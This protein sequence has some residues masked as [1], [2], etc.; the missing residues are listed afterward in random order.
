VGEPTIVTYKILVDGP[1]SS[2]KTSFIRAIS[3]IDV[4][5]TQKP[6]SKTSKDAKGKG[7]ISVA[8]DFG[9]ITSAD[10]TVTLY[11]FGTPGAWRFD[12]DFM[13]ETLGEGILG[14]VF[15]VDSRKPETFREAVYRLRNFRAHSSLPIVI[16]A[17][18]QDSPDAW[19][20]DTLRIAL[21]IPNDIPIIPC[22]A[23]DRE[24]V[25][26]VVIALLNEVLKD[27]ETDVD[28]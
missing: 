21:R 25:K 16:A 23:T 2:G 8:L 17:N 26:G 4:V 14:Y 12:F 24:S 19:D 18:K 1:F 22:V 27:V 15:M 11:L 28:E 7:N 20:V 10:S 3:E 5:S 13:R 9:R 6:I